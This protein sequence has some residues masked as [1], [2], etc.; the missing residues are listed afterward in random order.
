MRKSIRVYFLVI[1][2]VASLSAP[3]YAA[4]KNGG[5]A[6]SFFTRLKNAIIRIL[7]DS[8]IVIPPG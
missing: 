7:D 8:K 3:V 5:S 2:I 6:P 1:S 4:S